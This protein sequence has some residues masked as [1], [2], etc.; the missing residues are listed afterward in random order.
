MLVCRCKPYSLVHFFL[1]TFQMMLC[2]VTERSKPLPQKLCVSKVCLH[3]T[4][5]EH[6]SRSDEVS[7]NQ[8]TGRG[9]RGSCDNG[10]SVQCK[11]E[12]GLHQHAH[13]G[14]VGDSH[15]TLYCTIT[16]NSCEVEVRHC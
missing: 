2:L 9:V 12:G 8:G 5:A 3:F 7:M 1:V 10:W 14:E 11:I 13:K 6:W 15:T 4:R 16:A